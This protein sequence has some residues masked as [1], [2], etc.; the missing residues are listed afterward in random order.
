M[1]SI[2]STDRPDKPPRKTRQS[3]RKIGIATIPARTKPD[4]P[5][6]DFPL[7]P[8]GNGQWS[9]KIRG[10]VY[11]FGPWSD[12]DAA[13][14]R[15]L[16]VKDDLHAGRTPRARGDDRAT[17]CD[18]ANEFLTVKQHRVETGELSQRSL[19]EY[20]ATCQRLMAILGKNLVV[21]E[22]QSHDLLKVRETL[23]KSRG[24]VALGNEI[25]RVRVVLNFAYQEGIIDRPIRYG[26]SFR[27][28]S[29][30]TRR[31]HNASRELAN[32]KKLFSAD[33]IRV[34]IAQAD[35]H[36]RAM[37]LLA[38]NTG[39]GNA[40]LGRIPLQALD[41]TGGWLNYP[42][43]KTGIARR[44]PLWPETIKAIRESLSC[45]VR[46]KD[47]ELDGCLVFVTKYGASWFKEGTST[48]PL[49]QAFRKFCQ[50]IGVYRKGIGFCSL[51]HTFETVAGG[52]KDQVAVNYIMG[53][54]DDSMAANYRHGIEDDRLR[55]VVD[56]VHRWLFDAASG[57]DREQKDGN[58]NG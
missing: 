44:C 31:R 56:H 18:L 33:E 16:E 45:R 2:T 48:N 57:N 6:P 41:L 24:V 17:L 40:D 13:L 29:K 8:N 35:V 54:V 21:E 50:S 52:S 12:P 4:K 14:T 34:M 10:R 46:P 47:E 22:I 43:P 9:K 20:K 32:G 11:Y 23:G 42:R 3:A 37:V 25:G 1:P 58:P 5:R 27:K 39:C 51:R 38:V 7:T 15:Y 26:E 55:A 53:H 36:M 19:N 30:A 49:S 28:P